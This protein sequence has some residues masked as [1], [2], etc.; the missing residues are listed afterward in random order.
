MTSRGAKYWSA[1]TI[2]LIA[3]ELL[4]GIISSA[5][6]LSLVISPTGRILSVM[7]NPEH[8]GHGR[9]AHW[10]GKDIRDF[11]APESVVKLDAQLA[12][13]DGDKPL[14]GI[15]LNHSD[16]AT[17]EFP[18]RYTFHRIGPDGALLMLGRD[19]RPIAEMQQQLVKAQIALQKDYEEQRDVETRLRVL[20]DGTR[21]A[22]AFVQISTG[23]VVD[24]NDFA[25][26]ILGAPRD[27]I[28][29]SAFAQEFEG[30]RRGEFLESL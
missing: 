23:R 18:I 16:S 24:L 19:L 10:E 5:A 22:I 6:D 25:A 3:P 21:D 13:V 29:G 2:P 28:L 7:P 9:L 27:E 26:N 1:G 4:G 15:E 20:L 11:L 14:R 30:R 12:R 8:R 17:W